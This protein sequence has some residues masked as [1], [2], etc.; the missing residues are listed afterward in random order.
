MVVFIWVVHRASS[1]IILRRNIFGIKIEFFFIT[2]HCIL[3][4]TTSVHHSVSAYNLVL[5]Y[6]LRGHVHDANFRRLGITFLET[7][8]NEYKRRCLVN[9][10]I[11]TTNDSWN[12]HT[13]WKILKDIECISINNK[14]NFYTTMLL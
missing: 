10:S 1:C 5:A 8:S 13:N 9:K 6:R 3:G 12:K 4:Y 2:N 7:S 11:S 14:Q